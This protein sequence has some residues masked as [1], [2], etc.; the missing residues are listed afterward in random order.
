MKDFLKIE[1][2]IFTIVLFCNS[3]VVGF[4]QNIFNVIH[5]GAKGDGTSDDTQA[6]LDAFKALCGANEDTPTLIVP[7]EHSFFVRQ[8]T[9]RGPCKYQN[10][11]IKIDGHILAPHRNE[12]GTCSKRWLYFLN[13]H[14]M[15][16]DGSG[17]IDG[18][19]EAWW[20]NLNG[21]KGC[22]GTPPPTALLFERCDGL[23][24]SGLT[25]INGPGMHIYVVHS[26]D[27][28]ISHVNVTSPPKSRNTDG[29]DLSNSVRVNVHDSIIQSGDDCIAIKGGSQF[30]NITQVT[31]GPK[32]H[33]ISVGS[34]GG[35]G[36]EEFAENITV[37]NCTFN[38]AD[39]AARIKTYPGGKGYARSI[40]FDH[41][42]VNQIKNPIYIQQHYMKVPEKGDAVKISNVTFSNIYGTC[43]GD[44]AIFLDCAKIG[45][46]NITL[47]DIN[48]TSVDPKKPSS[49]ICNNVHGTAKNIT[50]PPFHCLDQ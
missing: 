39:S 22:T 35:G 47:Q 5:Y 28:T 46:D 20:G 44:N 18:Q 32:T 21:T 38:R 19:G 25:H 41:I 1:L 49:S 40:I 50:S 23:Q 3:L 34:L 37:K 12:W 13:V 10:L 36:A 48:I 8:I 26:Q 9:F 15:T 7:A 42:I 43:S 16:I 45:C 33:G 6:F 11:R 17:V 14:G 24:L 27:V 4:G 30:I 31:C 2:L 29:I